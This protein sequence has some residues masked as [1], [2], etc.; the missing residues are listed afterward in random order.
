MPETKVLKDNNGLKICHKCKD[1]IKE[2]VI[3]KRDYEIKKDNKGNIKS[4]TFIGTFYYDEAC[5]KGI[6]K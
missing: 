3:K 6:N 1:Y 5:Y 2:K 4:K